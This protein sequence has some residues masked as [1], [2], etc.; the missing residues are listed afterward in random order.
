MPGSGGTFYNSY[1]INSGDA[2]EYDL[3]AAVN[4]IVAAEQ[5][6]FS[7][8]TVIDRV[9]VMECDDSGELNSNQTVRVFW[10]HDWEL[11][12]AGDVPGL[13]GEG[14][15]DRFCALRVAQGRLQG[16]FSQRLYY[17]A[18]SAEDVEQEPLKWHRRGGIG[19]KTDTALAGPYFEAYAGYISQVAGLDFDVS[20][21]RDGR[22]I[23]LFE[24]S[25]PPVCHIAT[26]EV[27]ARQRHACHTADDEMFEMLT[28][29]MLTIVLVALAQYEAGYE[30]FHFLW[31][32]S[33]LPN[34]ID[35]GDDPGH[36]DPV[37]RRN[38]WRA[39]LGQP[40]TLRI[41]MNRSSPQFLVHL[42]YLRGLF[43]K[44]KS[45]VLEN[46]TVNFKGNLPLVSQIATHIDNHLDYLDGLAPRWQNYMMQFFRPGDLSDPRN[47]FYLDPG[48]AT[49]FW[50]DEWPQI[51]DM[52]F[53][54]QRYF[55]LLQVISYIKPS[56]K[57]PKGGQVFTGVQLGADV[58]PSGTFEFEPHFESKKIG[59]GPFLTLTD[60]T[61]KG[62][63]AVYIG[64]AQPAWN[65]T[66]DPV[67]WSAIYYYQL[68]LA[69]YV[70][71]ALKS[72]TTLPGFEDEPT[73]LVHKLKEL[74]QIADPDQQ[75]AIIV[76]LRK[77]SVVIFHG[78]DPDFETDPPIW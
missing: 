75:S 60:D 52:L 73:R 54:L 13:H 77:A 55:A 59:R 68:Q 33:E 4:N 30:N 19:L 6:L 20:L 49:T 27:L 47:P 62:T 67:P 37:I 36:Y 18:I 11:I 39:I 38:F 32:S 61:D 9:L 48:E 70:W 22:S 10:V 53:E 28:H 3:Q 72:D 16:R 57:T 26:I 43:A 14:S 64:P 45:L 5:C 42:G 71:V 51:E 46:Q 23:A 50:Y 34:R 17:D 12:R 58:Q 31:G 1:T 56:G 2:E 7:A 29:E 15:L 35:Q 66:T 41:D 24:P 69:S 78:D 21:D 44:W 74:Y 63:A 40:E 25:G 8:K 65:P 76:A